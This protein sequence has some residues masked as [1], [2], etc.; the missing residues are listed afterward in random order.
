MSET[1]LEYK[2]LRI[3]YNNSIEKS[4][5]ILKQWYCLSQITL[6]FYYYY[7]YFLYIYIYLKY[8]FR[9][10]KY[11]Q[12]LL[13]KAL[14]QVWLLGCCL[15]SPIIKRPP[16]VRLIISFT[17]KNHFKKKNLDGLCAL[18]PTPIWGPKLHANRIPAE[19][20]L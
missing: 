3:N 2:F 11:C 5:H 4:Q 10:H 19:L 6:L 15:G 18:F 8:H 13:S 14:E 17:W 7:Y 9:S 16:K 1:I 12:E 20:K